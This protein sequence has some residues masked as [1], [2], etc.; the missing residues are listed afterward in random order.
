LGEDPTVNLRQERVAA[1]L[2]MEAALLVPTGSMANLVAVLAQTRPGDAVLFH[3]DAHPLHYESGGIAAVAG[4]LAR[5]LEG[6][7]CKFTPEE[8][9][10]HIELRPDHH[11]APTT[12]AA[13]EN[14]A[15]RGGGAFHT[16]AEVAAL[17]AVCRASGVRLHC[18]G[19][20]IFN[21]CVATGTDIA[22]YARHLDTL[23]FCFSKGLGAPV[24]SI[25]AGDAETI[26][27]AHRYRKMLGGG[28]RQAGVLA[29]A[30]L[31]AL[32]HHIG[33]LADDHRRCATFRAALEGL[34]GVAFP[35]P[36][37]TNILFV[38]T[39]GAPALKERLAAR[40]VLV[41][42]TGPTRIRVV[43]HLDVDDEGLETAIRAFRDALAGE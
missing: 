13:I 28:M 40:G 8:L 25:L 22:E 26:D 11:F 30:A 18:D 43:F 31:Y 10:A 27:R 3:R 19:A 36:S 21:A 42:V 38:E 41:G 16:P 9:A 37:P 20:R 34:P 14:T 29:A 1:M 2:G 24:G 5:G 32:D 7:C 15:N 39:P 6:P 35:M 33:R 12:L 17:A 23:C 4:V